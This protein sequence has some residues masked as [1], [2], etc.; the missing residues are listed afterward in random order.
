MAVKIVKIVPNTAKTA[1]NG[2][3]S[4]FQRTIVYYVGIFTEKSLYLF[5]A[6]KPWWS[7]DIHPLKYNFLF[8]R[9]YNH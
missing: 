7:K 9:I 1:E 5:M 2:Y 3:Y 4:T 8:R 6:K